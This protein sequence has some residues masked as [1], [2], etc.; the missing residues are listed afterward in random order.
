MR[1]MIGK[2]PA[3]NVI[4]RWAETASLPEYKLDHISEDLLGRACGA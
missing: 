3:L 1:Y 2:V 4:L